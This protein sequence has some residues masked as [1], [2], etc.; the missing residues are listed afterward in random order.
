M[1]RGGKGYVDACGMVS[2]ITASGMRGEMS[3]LLVVCC[4]DGMCDTVEGCSAGMR[5][6]V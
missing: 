6:I 2:G 5:H 1:S 4:A 3:W